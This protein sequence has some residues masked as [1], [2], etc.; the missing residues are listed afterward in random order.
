MVFSFG[1]KIKVE[2]WHAMGGG[3]GKALE[4]LVAAFNRENP[5]IE[6]V[7]VYVG[8][9]GA[10]SRKLLSTVVAYN[11]GT[12]DNLPV[13]AQAYSN[14][15]SKYLQSEGIVE[16]LNKFIYGD[17]EFKNVWDNQIYDV[18]KKLCTWGDKIYSI[19]FNKSVYTTYYNVDIFDLYGVEPPKT[20]DELS[21]VAKELTDDIDGDGQI[22]QYGLGYRTTVDDFQ[23]F[24]YAM[25]GK[26]LDYAGNGKWKIVLDKDLTIKTLEYMHKLKSDEVAFVQGGY[27]NDPFGNGQIAM[28]MG[29]IAGKPYVEKSIKGKYEWSWAPLPSVDGVPHSPI[30]GTDLIMFAWA[31][32]A[33]KQAAWMFMNFLLTKVNQAYWAV[34][35]GYVPVR[36]DVVETAQWKAYVANDDKPAI[37]LDSLKTA[38]PDP[39]PAA[40]YD[41][42]KALGT[43]TADFLYDKITAEEA[44][45]R[46][47]NEMKN[48]LMENEEYS[49]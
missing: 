40:W 16:P 36:K 33:Q 32:P 42:R 14:W 2:F 30:A 24:L 7:P 28:Y 3:H 45:N 38:V 5:E 41:I 17:P 11:E 29:T 6:V 18:F 12:R 20:L 25:N 4:E 47:V 39:K 13:L 43:I 37:A 35:T 48:L 31:S 26:I 49:K 15:T 21:E 46:M 1:E 8:N 9:Y 23:V 34:N 22:D 10:L 44:Y 27:L 19:P